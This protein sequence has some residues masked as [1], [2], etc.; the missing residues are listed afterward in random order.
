MEVA[1]SN[2]G[3]SRPKENFSIV[4]KELKHEYFLKQNL[5]DPKKICSPN[6]FMKKLEKRM[7]CYYKG[8]YNSFIFNKK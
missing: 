4:E 6:R 5:F 2:K 3:K 8:L 1:S 7:D